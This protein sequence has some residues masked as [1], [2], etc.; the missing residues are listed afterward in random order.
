MGG[1]EFE[2]PD[3]FVNRHGQVTN[4]DYTVDAAG[5]EPHMTG[6]LAGGKSQFFFGVDAHTAALDAASYA[7]ENGLSDANKAKVF[8]TNGPV[9]VLGQSGV[10]TD[11]INVYRTN[12]GFVHASP[13]SAP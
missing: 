8:V 9:G 5:M 13:G 7:D 12:T 3:T 2:P 4:G 1:G 11:W 6:S 10:P